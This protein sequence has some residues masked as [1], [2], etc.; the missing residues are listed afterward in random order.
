MGEVLSL[1]EVSKSY[2]RGGMP[3][4]VLRDVTLRIGSGTIVAVVGERHE[5]KT[6]LL[7]IAAG[8]ERPD[9]GRVICAGQDLWT[10]STG[11]RERLWGDQIAWTSRTRPGLDWEMR[12]YVGLQLAMGRSRG[13]RGVQAQAALAL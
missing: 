9:H 1:S 13:R 8:I 5:G 4:L 11:E 7:K 12:D 6:T 3:H 2:W 10:L